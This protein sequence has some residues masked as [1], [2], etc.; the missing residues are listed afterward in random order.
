MYGNEVIHGKMPPTPTPP[1]QKSI[2]ANYYE[3]VH[4]ITGIKKKHSARGQR[5]A[6]LAEFNFTSKYTEKIIGSKIKFK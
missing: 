1:G 5:G 6:A 2:G 3:N 4:T